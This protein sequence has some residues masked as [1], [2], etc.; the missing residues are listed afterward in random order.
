M[1]TATIAQDQAA[2]FAANRATGTIALSVK[3]ARGGS[4]R[5]QVQEAGSLRARFPNGK[6]DAL[7]C[8]MVN[9]A[10]GMTGG[11]R[12]TVALD[13]GAHAALVAGTAAAEKIYRSLGP[14][15]EVSVT[16]KVG[17]RGQ[18][19]WLP[20][21]TILFDQ[22]RLRRCIDVDLADH[23][24]LLLCEGVVFGRAAMGEAVEDGTLIDRWRVR[25]NGRLIFAETMRLEGAIAGKLQ[26]P[27]ASNG[28]VALAT[29]LVVPGDETISETVRGLN[30]EF[31]GEVGVSAWNGLVLA[32]FCARDG[33]SLRH[34]LIRVLSAFKRAPLPRLWLS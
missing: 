28:A 32:R 10:G 2:V 15:T 14:D 22:A 11:D 30:E 20:Q 8:V 3:A 19:A 13:V 18:L 6:G 31:R 34:D 17:E 29:V 1:R 9:T 7:E 24:S 5:A 33:E 4:R 21:E 16:L 25:R 26:E 23:A 12:F 27:A